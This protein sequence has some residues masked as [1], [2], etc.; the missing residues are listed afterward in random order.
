MFEQGEPAVGGLD[1]SKVRTSRHAATSIVVL[2]E[3]RCDATQDSHSFDDREDLPLYCGVV[4]DHGLVKEP[5]RL[6]HQDHITKR[7]SRP[8]TAP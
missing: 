4:I 3:E 2:R 5:Q 6:W 7:T 8:R 1:G